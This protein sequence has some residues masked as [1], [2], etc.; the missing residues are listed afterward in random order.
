MRSI[1]LAAL[2]A[3]LLL[4]GPTAADADGWR[5]GAPAPE[6]ALTALDGQPIDIAA[7]KGKVVVANVWATWC[8]PCRAEMPMLDAFYQAHR[9]RGVVLLGLSADRTRDL[10][11]VRKVMAAFSYPAGLLAAARIDHLGE[12]RILPVTLVIDRAGVVR[13]VFGANGTPLT[14]ALLEA[15]VKPL[16]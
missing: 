7:L 2:V 13:S 9:G 1:V 8:G 4:T 5:V 11:A 12:P 16:L 3:G 14:Q 6:V 10:P 15:A